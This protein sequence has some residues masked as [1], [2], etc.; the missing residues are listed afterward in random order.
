VDE[1]KPMLVEWGANPYV[2][3][4]SCVGP[5]TW[6]SAGPTTRAWL[7]AEPYTATTVDY[8]PPKRRRRKRVLVS[9]GEVRPGLI[10]GP[11]WVMR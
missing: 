2:P 6:S 4:W 1:P 10:T 9:Q 8:E 11:H 7:V 3:S 5:V